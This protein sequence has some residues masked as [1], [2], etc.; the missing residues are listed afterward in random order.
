MKRII[1]IAAIGLLM[2]SCVNSGKI[3]PSVTGT[4]YENLVVMNDTYWKGAEGDSVRAKL[5]ADMVCMPQMEPLF[6][7]SQTNFNGFTDILKPV[8]NIFIA[9]IDSTQYTQGKVYYYKDQWAK[10]QVVVK[11]AA[12]D[13]ETFKQLMSQYGDRIAQHFVDEEIKRQIEVYK[14]YT[15]AKAKELAM[16]KFGIMVNI[17]NDMSQISE[18]ENFLWATDNKSRV[19]RDIVIYSFPYTDKDTFTKEYLLAKRDSIMKHHIPG[20]VEGSYMGTEYNHIP[21]VFKAINVR[22]EYCAELRGLWRMINGSA[23]GGPFVSHTR[24]DEINQRVI[25]IEGFVY[26]AGSK[27]RNA[28]RQVEAVLYSMQLPQEINALPEVEIV[29]EDS[30]Q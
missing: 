1:S 3:L 22:G 11:V 8:R 23:M 6:S 27:K 26:G 28:L 16:Q 13:R 2:A 5:A 30:L 25:M 15:N 12:P 10:P 7:L 4:I 24:L 19:R 29:S 18:S 14:G 17:P 20:D 21:P 9:D